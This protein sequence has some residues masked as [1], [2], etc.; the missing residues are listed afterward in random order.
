MRSLLETEATEF[1]SLEQLVAVCQAI[2]EPRDVGDLGYDIKKPAIFARRALGAGTGAS[3]E[4]AV[5]AIETVADRA[6]DVGSEGVARGPLAP[7]QP[8]ETARRLSSSSLPIVM[9]G[10]SRRGLVRIVVEGD[11]LQGPLLENSDVFSLDRLR[12]W[13]EKYPYDY[14]FARQANV[15]FTSTE[16]LGLSELPSRCLLVS[17]AEL[18]DFPPALFNVGGEL[19]GSTRRIASCPSL[20]WLKAARANPRTRS[21]RRVA[22]IPTV[23]AEEQPQI[24]SVLADRLEPDLKR[25]SVILSREEELPSSAQNADILVVVAHGGTATRN[26]YFRSIQ[27]DDDVPTSP[28]TIAAGAADSGT[29]Q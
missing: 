22:W 8:L 5:F 13:R 18:Q 11:N 4:L 14:A 3:A 16:H 2:Q 28:S 27:N 24:L 19:A 23:A 21:G 9:L 1:P 15:F 25:H 17:D 12:E 7:S 26:R 29:C 20:E 6:L 10:K